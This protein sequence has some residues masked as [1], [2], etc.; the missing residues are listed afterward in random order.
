MNIPH[1]DI[2]PTQKDINTIVSTILENNDASKTL[3]ANTV[4][5]IG[6]IAKSLDTVKDKTNI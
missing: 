2:I 3:V 1:Q 6:A 5:T 4:K